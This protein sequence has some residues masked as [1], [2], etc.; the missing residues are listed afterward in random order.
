MGLGKKFGLI[1]RLIYIY[2]FM[3]MAV[4]QRKGFLE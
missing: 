1:F 2:I 4:D 3:L